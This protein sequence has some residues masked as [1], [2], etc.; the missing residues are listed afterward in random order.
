LFK[1]DNRIGEYGTTIPGP[2]GKYGFGKKCLPKETRGMMK[3]QESLDMDSY[4]IFES[5]LQRN[6]HFRG[7]HE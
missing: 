3:L 1:L 2:D 7:E 4:K 5:I 6:Y